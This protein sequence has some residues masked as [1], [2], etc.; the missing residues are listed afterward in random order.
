[1]TGGLLYYLAKTPR[2]LKACLLNWADLHQVNPFTWRELETFVLYELW[3][4]DVC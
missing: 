3:D 4:M 2:Y 1:M